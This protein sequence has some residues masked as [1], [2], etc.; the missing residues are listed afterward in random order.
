M[1]KGHG[2]RWRGIFS[3]LTTSMFLKGWYLLLVGLRDEES[4]IVRVS[5]NVHASG[6]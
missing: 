6:D 2:R 3:I 5:I 1:G 4:V